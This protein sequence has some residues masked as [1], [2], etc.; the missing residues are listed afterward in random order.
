VVLGAYVAPG[1]SYAAPL[2][3]WLRGRG[4][5]VVV[6]AP[7]ETIRLL[8]DGV[9]SAGLAPLGSI[10]ASGGFKPCPGPMV[11]S[12]G[13][14]L[15]VAVFSRKPMRLVECRAVSVTAETRTSVRY[16]SLVLDELKADTVLVASKTTRASK[17]LGLAPCALVIGDEAL[18]AIASGVYLVADLGELVS[19]V[20]GV[21]PVYA[22]TVV[23]SNTPC[24]RGL[25]EPPWPRPRLEDVLATSRATGLDPGMAWLYH[26]SLLRFDYNPS[27]LYKALA[28]LEK[29]RD[30]LE[31]RLAIFSAIQ[32]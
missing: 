30:S 8:R 27:A 5:R 17:L 4:Y 14:T 23:E 19:R 18:R 25:A 10:A 26:S 3:R 13:A 21:E 2:R 7:P 1:Y 32:H 22:A 31:A 20:L 12:L 24:P 15:S 6:A 28:L 9:A 16:L 29:S 11:Y